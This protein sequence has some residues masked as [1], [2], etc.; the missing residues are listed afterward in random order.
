MKIRINENER[1]LRFRKGKYAGILLPG[2]YRI[3]RGSVQAVSLSDPL[4]SEAPLKLLLARSRR[5]ERSKRFRG[6]GGGDRFALCQ[7]NFRRRTDG[8]RIRVFGR[9]MTAT[10]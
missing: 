5:G 6:E 7:R 1:G 9:S 3:F 8:G 10:R 2:E 4:V